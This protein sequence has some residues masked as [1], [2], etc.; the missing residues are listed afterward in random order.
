MEV[1]VTGSLQIVT[2]CRRD[3]LA[4]T[5]AA[6]ESSETG[7]IEI[8]S[9]LTLGLSGLG[10]YHRSEFDEFSCAISGEIRSMSDVRVCGWSRNADTQFLR[11]RTAQQTQRTVE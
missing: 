6:A 3:N 1:F 8:K 10:V 5:R 2:P 7:E 11:L 4:G 9:A